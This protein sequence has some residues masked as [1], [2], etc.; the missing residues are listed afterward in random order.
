MSE[1]PDFEHE[2]R[3][4]RLERQATFDLEKWRADGRA[5][6]A[7]HPNEL[8]DFIARMDPG[9]SEPENALETE[10]PDDWADSEDERERSVEAS[11]LDQHL[12]TQERPYSEFAR[13]PGPQ[14]EGATPEE[15]AAKLWGPS[16]GE[17]Q[18]DLEMQQAKSRGLHR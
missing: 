1:T 2:T 14:I 5:Y 6:A 3:E 16:P 12:A 13:G 7:E 8:R 17:K 4:T 15:L 18:L 11:D 9:G 10:P